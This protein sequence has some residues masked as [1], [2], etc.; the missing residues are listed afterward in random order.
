[1]FGPDTSVSSSWRRALFDEYE[2]RLVLSAQPLG[3]F[4]IDDALLQGRFRLWFAL[5]WPAFGA[6]V[7]V[8]WLMVAKPG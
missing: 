5:G 2:Q 6:L 3:D 4:F 7:A 8:F 1:M